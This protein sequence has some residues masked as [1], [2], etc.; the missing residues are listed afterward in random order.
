MGL[1]AG[2]SARGDQ[3]QR[4]QKGGGGY[5]L[6]QKATP[7]WGSQR[8][9]GEE[10]GIPEARIHHYNFPFKACPIAYTQTHL[11]PISLGEGKASLGG[12]MGFRIL[13]II[14]QHNFNF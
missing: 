11:Y 13:E 2:L 5:L 10:M 14:L 4:G 7:R 9:L 3:Q 1:G 8:P 6:G 12:Q